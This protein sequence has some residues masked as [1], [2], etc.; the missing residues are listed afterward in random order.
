MPNKPT[1]VDV[2]GKHAGF[3]C[4]GRMLAG[5]RDRRDFVSGQ[6]QPQHPVMREVTASLQAATDW[7]LANTPVGT[8]GCS[9]PTFAIPLRNL[10]LAFARIGTVMAAATSRL[11]ALDEAD[12]AFMAS[13]SQPVLRNW[14]GIE[15]DGL[16]PS[17]TLIAFAA[18]TR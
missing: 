6:L 17:G 7:D 2:P 15:V 5:E 13:L 14:N 9:I 12:A 1:L 3:V 10:A 18:A 11:L 8:D 16:W 4:L